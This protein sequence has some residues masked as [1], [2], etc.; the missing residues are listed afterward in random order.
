MQ[1]AFTKLEL[2]MM[3]DFNIYQYLHNEKTKED[4][5]ESLKIVASIVD[6][7]ELLSFYIE[8]ALSILENTFN[9]VIAKMLLQ[10][11]NRNGEAYQVWEKLLQNRYNGLSDA[12]VLQ[13]IYDALLM[14]VYQLADGDVTHVAEAMENIDT[15]ITKLE[16]DTVK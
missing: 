15:I 8:V 6:E 11:D 4:V 10:H 5:I 2:V 7:N 13:T 12:N 3:I 14:Y 9:D 1:I 16:R